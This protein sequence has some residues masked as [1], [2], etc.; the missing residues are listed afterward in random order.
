VRAAH[1]R[2]PSGE[3]QLIAAAEILLAQVDRDPPGRG[4]GERDLRAGDRIR[5][6]PAV[7]DQV[8]NGE[9]HL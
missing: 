3:R 5:R 9:A 7:G 1:G 4:C 6:E 2:E 8:D